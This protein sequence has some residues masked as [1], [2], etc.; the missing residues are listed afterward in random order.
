MSGRV[1]AVAAV[2]LIA[3][4]AAGGCGTVRATLGAYRSVSNA[5]VD[6][7]VAAVNGV[8][9]RAREGAADAR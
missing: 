6:D 3:I 5:G 9:N 1:I 2:V 4:A 8:A 7:A